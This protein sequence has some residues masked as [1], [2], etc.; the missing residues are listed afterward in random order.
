[1][2]DPK[3]QYFEAEDI[4]HID[5]QDGAEKSSVEL[6]PNTAVELNAK[7]EIIGI[8]ILHDSSYI[9]DNVLETAQGKLLQTK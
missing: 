6:S 7:S 8:E 1:M 4:I 3:M 9:R 2:G 5:I